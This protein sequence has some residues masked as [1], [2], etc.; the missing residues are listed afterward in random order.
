MRVPPFGVKLYM[1]DIVPCG[2]TLDGADDA[3]IV[4]EPQIVGVVAGESGGLE[5]AFI[6]IRLVGDIELAV[7]ALFDAAVSAE[8]G[9]VKQIAVFLLGFEL[10]ES[11]C[12]P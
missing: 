4:G 11:P 2:E 3:E 6:D 12:Q 5:R 10:G 9:V 7:E 1:R 8:D